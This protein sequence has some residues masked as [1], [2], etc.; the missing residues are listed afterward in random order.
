MTRLDASDARNSSGPASSAGSPTLPVGSWRK[1]WSPYTGA[2]M[3][4]LAI[5]LGN[6]PGASVLTRTPRPA[7][8]SARF[9][10]RWI[11]AAFDAW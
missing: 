9:R 2:S 7:H 1:M 4:G 10:V 11:T 3:N 6:Q 8:D 5:S